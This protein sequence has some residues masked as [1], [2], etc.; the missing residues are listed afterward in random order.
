M[1]RKNPPT[2]TDKDINL[3]SLLPILTNEDK[4]REF[5]E[6]KRW[7]NGPVCP[8]CQCTTVYTLTPREGSKTPVRKGVFKCKECRKQFSVRV[9]TIFEDSK[10][11]IHKWLMA[12]HLMCTAKN[13]ISSH[14]L[15]RQ[16][17]ITQK[18]AWF[19]CHRIRESM[20]LE[21]MAGMLKGTV[22][23]DETYCGPRKPRYK[24]TS[25]SG[26][27]TSKKPVLALVERGGRVVAYP[28]DSAN[29]VTLKGSIRE[30]VDPSATIVTDEHRC[31]RG[32]GKDFAGGHKTVNHSRGEYVR[33]E[34]RGEVFVSTNAVE[35]FFARIKRAHMGVHHQMSKRHLG[36]YVDE[37]VFKHNSSKITDGE[38]LVQAIRGAEG[39]RLMYREPVE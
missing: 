19:V 15:A 17:D 37:A 35:G 1:P 16:L 34:Q 4:A 38:R 6:K 7:P 22:E 26:P 11:P 12:I 21:P 18:T 9:G 33:V 36:R 24:G 13:G 32:I 20:K 28:I 25:K 39:K 27:G 2:G 31:Y 8:H 14:E 10:L 29:A 30:L 5:L 23:V 3:A